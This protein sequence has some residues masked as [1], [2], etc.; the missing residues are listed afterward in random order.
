MDFSNPEANPDASRGAPVGPLKS[1]FSPYATGKSTG[2]HQYGYIGALVGLILSL[3]VASGTLEL[4]PGP[5]R[6][7]G[8]DQTPRDALRLRHERVARS[9]LHHPARGEAA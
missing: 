8:A 6:P 4:V 1:W 2:L 3:E 5:A 9:H 7:A